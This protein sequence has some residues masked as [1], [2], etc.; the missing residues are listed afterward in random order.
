MAH[1]RI[2]RFERISLGERFDLSLATNKKGENI[3]RPTS[4]TGEFGAD[5]IRV[6]KRVRASRP[7]SREER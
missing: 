4:M 3:G 6:A 2:V 5:N 7:S 1:A